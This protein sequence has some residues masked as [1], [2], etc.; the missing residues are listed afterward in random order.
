MELESV[1]L[2]AGAV[3]LLPLFAVGLSLGKYFSSIV[4][5]IGRNPSAEPILRK[6]NLLYF[7]LIEAI[8][9]FALGISLLILKG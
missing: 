5:A 7:A 2:I 4:E 6:T 1:K 9:I 3:A 8:A